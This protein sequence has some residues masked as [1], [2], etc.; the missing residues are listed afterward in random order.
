MVTNMF[1]F[2]HN[3]FK[4]PLSQDLLPK[5]N[6]IFIILVLFDDS[7]PLSKQSF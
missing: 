7:Q 2:S 4:R 1:I 5:A 3:V 6:W